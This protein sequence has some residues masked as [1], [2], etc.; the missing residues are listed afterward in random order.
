MPLREQHKVSGKKRPWSLEELSLGLNKF[1]EENKRYPTA[2]EV[3]AYKFLPSARSIERSFGGLIALRKK[4]GLGTEHDFRSGEHSRKRARTIN[5]RA[6]V[7]QNKV[8]KFLVERFGKEFVHRE[9]FFTDDHRTRAD[10]FVYDAGKGFCV[11]IFYPSS[12][13]NMIGCLNLKLGK[14]ASIYMREYP[15]IYVQMNID[16]PEDE[17]QKAVRNKTKKIPDGQRLMGWAAF[18]DFCNSHKSLKIAGDREWS[19]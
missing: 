17:V 5:D 1:F 12:R 13:R 6:H 4:L 19:Q 14:Y 2:H 7:M 11:D 15:V 3:D 10:F 9:Y 18:Q 16:I 8:Y